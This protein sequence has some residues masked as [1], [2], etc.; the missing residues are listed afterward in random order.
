VAVVEV[1]EGGERLDDGGLGLV[2]LAG[3]DRREQVG[4]VPPGERRGFVECGHGP[5]DLGPPG[6]LLPFAFSGGGK[7]PRVH[8]SR[9]GGRGD[10]R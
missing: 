2:D 1:T 8:R 9:G 5:H 10:V 4:E 7:V 6:R 3:V